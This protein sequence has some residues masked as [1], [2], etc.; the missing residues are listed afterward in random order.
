MKIPPGNDA[1]D[2]AAYD[3][4]NES[5]NEV[6]AVVD[7][8]HRI[9]TGKSND[10]AL[11]LGGI[12][13]SLTV[14]L[15]GSSPFVTG[16]VAAG[17]QFGGVG[18]G[19]TQQLQLTAK[20]ADG[21][22]IV[23]PGGP[24]M[25]LTSSA[26]SKLVTAAVSG[27]LGRFNVTPLQETNALHS[28]DPG[29]AVT[30]TASAVAAG[31]GIAPVSA[32]AI[33][34]QN[35][36]IAYVGTY[37]GP[38]VIDAF[39]PWQTAPVLTIPLPSPGPGQTTSTTVDASGNLYAASGGALAVAVYPPGS[40]TASRT[41]T[42]VQI[43]PY[44]DDIVADSL[45]DIYA[46]EE[47]G[48][49]SY[50]VDEFTPAGGNTPAVSVASTQDPTGVAVDAANNFYVAFLS[51]SSLSIYPSGSS[52]PSATITS[53]I[54]TPIQPAF[55][56][57]GNLYVANRGGVNVTEYHPPFS[58]SSAPAV[59]FGTS[60]TLFEPTNLAI[61]E[62]GNLYVADEGNGN[63]VEYAPSS[64]ATVVRTLPASAVYDVAVDTLG[65]VYVPGDAAGGP[66]SVYPPGTSTT[67]TQTWSTGTG[68]PWSITVWP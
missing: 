41:V 31:T 63:V 27:S 32:A 26:P 60:A 59:T 61:D 42:G 29:T 25:T 64:P 10:V 12:P 24:T 50:V 28:P 35:D 6:S 57:H 14:A 17:L 1:F 11:T 37:S 44:I 47:A 38:A 55:D 23:N 45:G 65:Y 8:A 62:S 52:S 54:A 13:A 34:V 48:A 67:A 39:A 66:L 51:N 2:V 33:S 7:L 30:L 46:I 20:D 36:P 4:A 9:V 58:S 53:G 22:T 56:S 5:G 21:Y 3:G 49:G 68:W 15:V 18:S 16:S 19:A 43:S 40:T